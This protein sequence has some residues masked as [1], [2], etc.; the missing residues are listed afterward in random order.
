MQTLLAMKSLLTRMGMECRDNGGARGPW[1]LKRATGGSPR[2][3]L[4]IMLIRLPEVT[5]VTG[6]ALGLL[7][8]LKVLSSTMSW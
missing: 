2:A 3:Y 4:L 8:I 6:A 7:V 1:P 5:S